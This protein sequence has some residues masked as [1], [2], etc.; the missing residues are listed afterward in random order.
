MG[1]GV[2]PRRG[3][4]AHR[5]VW[6]DEAAKAIATSDLAVVPGLGARARHGEVDRLVGVHVGVHGLHYGS[7][8]FEGIRCYETS[9]G[10]AVFRL[11]EHMERFERSANMLLMELGYSVAETVAAVLTERSGAVI[12]VHIGGWPADMDPLLELAEQQQCAQ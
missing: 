10:P 8:V 11:T 5:T 12:P 7:G 3:F 6:R 4:K 1:S 2:L 9:D